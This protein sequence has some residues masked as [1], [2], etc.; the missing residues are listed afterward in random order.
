MNNM[1]DVEFLLKEICRIYDERCKD[2]SF[3][4]DYQTRRT[5][6]NCIEII[7]NLINFA[8]KCLDCPHMG[9]AEELITI[10]RD[11]YGMEVLRGDD[12]EEITAKNSV[13]SVTVKRE[14][15]YKNDHCRDE[16]STKNDAK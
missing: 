9:A 16:R 3:K 2:C 10:L 1:G 15:R 14:R 13:C 6:G 4:K 12:P 5:K 11:R 8:G 7:N